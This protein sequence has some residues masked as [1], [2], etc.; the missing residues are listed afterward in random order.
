MLLYGNDSGI[1]YNEVFEGGMT[2]FGKSLVYLALLVVALVGLFLF[3]KPISKDQDFITIVDEHLTPSVPTVVD[4]PI[5]EKCGAQLVSPKPNEV[6]YES[7][8]V[9]LIVAHPAGASCNWVVFE[10]LGGRVELL[11]EDGTVIGSA[12]LET[13]EE[14][15]TTEPVL[16]T[17]TLS[18]KEINSAN[19]QIRVT[20]DD[21]SGMGIVDTITIPVIF[22]ATI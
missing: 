8:L 17:G 15:M 20:E 5:T 4:T 1:Y 13:I 19:L 11:D 7:I 9:E 3:F 18:V 2:R 14:W 10:G 6:V 12:L 21:P 22:E 16:F